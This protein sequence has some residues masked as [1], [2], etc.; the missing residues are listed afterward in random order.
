MHFGIKL[1]TNKTEVTVK[2]F[3]FQMKKKKVQN[4]VAPIAPVVH[5]VPRQ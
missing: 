4:C 2:G 1:K 3:V 5:R